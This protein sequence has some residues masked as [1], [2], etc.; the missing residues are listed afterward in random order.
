MKLIITAFLIAFSHM[1]SARDCHAPWGGIV[2]DG[3]DVIAYRE[4]R[5]T[6]GNRCEYQYRRCRN[7]HLSGYYR[8]RNCYEDYGCDTTEFG[9]LYNGQSITAYLNPA[10]Y[11]GQRCQSEIRTCR[12][13]RLSGSYRYR[14][15]SEY[16]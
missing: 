16:K 11:G 2:R 10:E 7:G 4:P 9:Y 15:C 5:A 6:N 3:D 13:G 8:Y 12:Y 1:A 14:Y